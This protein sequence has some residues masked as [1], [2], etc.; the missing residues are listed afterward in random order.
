M[1]STASG[2]TSYRLKN[3]PGQWRA[4]SIYVHKEQTGE[5]VYE[6]P[7]VDQVPTLMRELVDPFG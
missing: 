4:G 3:R 2:M 5:I 1:T 7:D 6:G